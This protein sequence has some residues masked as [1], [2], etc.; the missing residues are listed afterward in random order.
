MT[1]YPPYQHRVQPR[2]LRQLWRNRL[3]AIFV[4]TS[5]A[6]LVGF[7][8]VRAL[9][10]G[11]ATASQAIAIML[12][13][14]AVGGIAGFVMKSSWTIII[15]PIAY[16][17]AIELGQLSAVGPTV[18]PIRLDSTFGVLALAVGR[19]FHGLVALLPMV[20]GASLGTA[21]ARRW[22]KSTVARK[23]SASLNHPI[24]LAALAA[25]VIILA[26]LIAWPA[27][28]PAIIAGD[29]QPASESIAR[30]EK[31]QIGGHDQ[32]IMLRGHSTDNPVLLYLSG[33]P[34][35]SDLSYSR[36]FFEDLTRD[37]VVVGWDQR[38]TGKSY[39]ALDPTETLTLEQAI[40]DTAELSD[41]LG[42][43]FKEDKIYLL[44][45]SWGSLLGVLTVQK[46][47]ELYHAFIGSGQM[48]DVQES[49]R[50]IYQALLKDA[51]TAGDTSRLKQL[52][53]Y[54]E[55][56]YPDIPYAN[57]FIMSQYPRLEKPYTPPQAYIE[58]GTAAG[59]GP[60]N[61]L[62][63]EYSLVEKANVL[64]GLLDMFTV[65][66]PQLQSIDFR[67]SVQQLAVPLYVLDGAAELPARR[68]L[69]LEWFDQVIAPRKEIFTF[70]N[71][72][73][74]VAFEQSEALAQIMLETVL[75][76][77]YSN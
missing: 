48:V 18:G 28:T 66:Y 58:R 53:R 39:A 33:G 24:L 32:W 21:T 25:G 20:L 41:Y 52:Q 67:Q 31:V 12:A 56:P 36:V 37:F 57:G 70:E 46:H 11:P 59:L 75:P 40:A 43:R 14:L 17:A 1:K 4:T 62:G 27:S 51:Q 63:S 64:R 60:W 19:G 49:D 35:Q 8:I 9:P 72:A 61:L 45:E 47:P 34:G 22:A 73:H 68:D 5:I 65:M 42:D 3:L 7:T 77:T 30:L 29:G 55:P 26:V 71:A 44:G 69:L 16:V 38:G 10:R 23:T 15:A 6:L 54:G 76:E 13:G 50:R 2:Q 74:S